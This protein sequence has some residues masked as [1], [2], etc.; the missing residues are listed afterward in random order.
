MNS[1]DTKLNS[2]NW[3][4]GMLL[5]PDH[6]LRQEK[7]L[8]SAILW[9]LRY[10][11][12][13]F[14]LI[15]GGPRLAE[16][17]RGAV[18]HDPIVVV[19]EDESGLNLSVSQC[20][21]ITPGGSMID[22]TPE[23]P[24]HRRYSKA[25]LEGVSE[26]PVYV[27]AEPYRKETLDGP[28]DDFN[29]QMQTERRASYTIALQLPAANV[30]YGIAVAR[31]RRAPYGTAYEKDSE[32]IP[33]CT[34]LVSY[35]ELTSAWR[36]IVEETT[37]L[38]ERYTEL[39][40]AMR[41]FLVLF[42]ER[43]IETEVDVEAVAFVDRM[44]V[45]L[46][47]CIY[48]ILDPMQSPA[49]FFGYLR[50]F[51]HSAAVFL[52]LNPPVLQYF[53]VLKEAGETEFISLIEQ[54]K[55][56]LQMSRRWQI[57]DDLSVEVRSVLQ[58]LGILRRLER[59]LEGKYI[60]FRLSPSLEAMNF[61]FD[62]GGKVLYKLAAKP[63][64]VQGFAD[65]LAMHFAQLRL[66][67]RD[68]YRLILVAEPDGVFEKGTRVNVEVRINEGAGFRRQ[69]VQGV[70]E[71]KLSGQRN[72]EMDFDAPDVATITDLRVVLQAHHPIRTA[73]LFVRHRFYAGQPEEAQAR[74]LLREERPPAPPEPPSRQPPVEPPP[75][76]RGAAVPSRSPYPELPRPP[77]RPAPW[78]SPRRVDR[79][80]EPVPPPRRRRL[81][82]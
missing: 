41:E 5:T 15:G 34:T 51:F 11:T 28:V 52:D 32:F 2:V 76:E 30:P 37:L 36:R 71:V 82:P 57:S 6:F 39:H 78:D 38:V 80:D 53:N 7:Y 63:S 8:E 79:P 12:D 59:A 46:Q 29:P 22:I 13:A 62:R 24:V 20:R 72:F 31:L 67:G 43:G 69:P 35:S 74:P 14:G 18:R 1:E 64:R 45:A 4:H 66:E 42:T 56:I 19:A 21:G 68:K 50:R 73:L 26:A 61:I 60:D 16:S 75:R 23:F 33:P 47:N 49:R 40:R 70:C 77:E 27:M 10:A 81:E 9:V 55:R 25:E 58:S 44:V 17:E 65:E 54:Q 48:E 3:E